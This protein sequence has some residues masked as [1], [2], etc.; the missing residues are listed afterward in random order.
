MKTR[1]NYT[2]VE[3]TF[4]KKCLQ[5]FVIVVKGRVTSLTCLASVSKPTNKSIMNY[6]IYTT[7]QK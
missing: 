1:S 4:N 5:H 6:N 3:K 7:R 2:I